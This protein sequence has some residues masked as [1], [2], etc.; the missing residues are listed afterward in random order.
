MRLFFCQPSTHLLYVHCMYNIQEHREY[1]LSQIKFDSHFHTESKPLTT[2]IICLGS[3]AI[4]RL[5]CMRCVSVV[6]SNSDKWS[7]NYCKGNKITPKYTLPYSKHLSN[8]GK[9][10]VE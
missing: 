1:I 4:C 9:K 6:N 7:D 2:S 10:S 8:F 3:L 5:M